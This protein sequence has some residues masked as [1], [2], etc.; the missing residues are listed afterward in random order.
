MQTIHDMR[1]SI[2]DGDA[3]VARGGCTVVTVVTLDSEI[4]SGETGV[5]FEPLVCVGRS[6]TDGWASGFCGKEVGV[7][8]GV[9]A[10]VIII[11]FD[12]WVGV[13]EIFAVESPVQSGFCFGD[14]I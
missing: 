5:T 12:V 9:T 8:D 10:G 6:G 1:G 11:L 3:G 14:A 2:R 13:P 7:G 4:V